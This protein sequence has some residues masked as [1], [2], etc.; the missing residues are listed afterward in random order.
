MTSLTNDYSSYWSSFDYWRHNN[1]ISSF[2][3]SSS[4]PWWQTCDQIARH[5]RAAVME[6]SCIHLER[7]RFVLSSSGLW[8]TM[9]GWNVWGWKAVRSWRDVSF[10]RSVTHYQIG[11]S[12]TKWQIWIF[13]WM[14]MYRPNAMVIGQGN[15][16]PINSISQSNGNGTAII[17]QII[18]SNLWL[19]GNFFTAFIYMY[20]RDVFH[21]LLILF[22]KFRN[23][24]WM[25]ENISLDVVIFC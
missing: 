10:P 3:F 18:M 12:W 23:E 2:F 7:F 1:I 21:F 25:I 8:K 22:W 17:V 20:F 6:S 4:A 5:I 14:E 13:K 11:H 16:C 15:G 24:V 9:R 19:F